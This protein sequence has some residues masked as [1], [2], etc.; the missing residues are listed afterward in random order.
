MTSRHV[1]K[2]ALISVY[3]K[4]GLPEL[5]EALV[6]H[7]V[8]IVSSGGTAKALKAAQVP[9][10]LVEELTQFPEMMGGRIKTLHPKIHGG[11]LAR[12]DQDHQ[13]MLTHEI[14]GIDLVVVNLYPF[15]HTLKEVEGQLDKAIEQID[16]GGPTL[17]RGAAKNHQWTTVVVHPS[18]YPQLIQWLAD[19]KGALELTQRVQLAQKAFVCSARYDAFI[20]QAFAQHTQRGEFEP[21]F[22][23]MYPLK[24]SLRYGENPHQKAAF[25]Q[26]PNPAPNT[27]TGATQLAG[28]ALSFNNI[29]DSDTALECVKTLKTPSCVIVKH[30]NPCGFAS[31]EDLHRAY[32][33]A[34]SCDPTSS[35][36]GIIAFNRS[37]DAHTLMAILE[38]QFVEVILAPDFEPQAILASKQKPNV[39]LLAYGYEDSTQGQPSR[40]VKQVNGGLLI[41]E[42]DTQCLLPDELNWVTHNTGDATQ[43]AELS[44]AWHMVKFV[45]SNAIVLVK[46]QQSIGIGAGQ[47]S[48][49]MSVDIALNQAQKQNFSLEGAVMASDAFFPFK[50]GVEIAAAKGIRAVIQPG[51]SIRDPEVIDAANA[52]G[53]AMAFTGYRHFSH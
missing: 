32:Q 8:E 49:V 2:R 5:A 51:G 44:L 26:D 23:P 10:T 39:R 37:V 31:D 18:D 4:T 6:H 24:T 28:K 12:R 29:A 13:D 20:A 16:I 43:F 41:Q 47:M 27:I 50:D 33:K 45:K 53:I 14:T 9:V 15:E 17:L 3:D 22:A 25:Y 1:I 7:G 19:Q 46:D 34:F 35:F 40:M 38:Q 11:I 52:H 30:A 36:G 48:R 21:V 42:C